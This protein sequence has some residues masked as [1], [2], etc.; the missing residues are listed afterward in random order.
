MSGDEST[1]NGIFDYLSGLFES[2]LQKISRYVDTDKAEEYVKEV[3][4]MTRIG[5]ALAKKYKAEGIAEG[6]RDGIDEG[7][8]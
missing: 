6:R 1:E 2:N 4:G 8:T 7:K 5:A 3:K